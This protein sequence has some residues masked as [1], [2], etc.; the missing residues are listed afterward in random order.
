M[1]C[2]CAAAAGCPEAR[3]ISGGFG[4]DSPLARV[5]LPPTREKT[6]SV[7]LARNLRQDGPSAHMNI[8]PMLFCLLLGCLITLLTI[9][10]LLLPGLKASLLTQLPRQ[11]RGR[12]LTDLSRESISKFGG[13]SLATSFTAVSLLV[14]FFYPAAWRDGGQTGLTVLLTGLGI[15]G[16]GLWDDFRPLGTPRRLILQT[17]VAAIA[18]FRGVQIEV[19]SPPLTEFGM[20]LG[21]WSGVVTL[22][23][24]V[25]L[26][27][28]FQRINAV[29]GLAGGLGL[30]SMALLAHGAAATGTA[31][32]GLCAIGMA[33]ALIGFLV[34]NLPPTRIQLGSSGAGLLGF[35]VGNLSITAPYR[36]HQ[37][38]MVAVLFIAVIGAS[39]ATWRCAIKLLPSQSL[40]P[41]PVARPASRIGAAPSQLRDRR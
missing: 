11:T 41:K 24:L 9:P 39:F 36:E 30:F 4:I 15:F 23:W 38:A 19:L 14:C 5:H 10:L 13:A 25:L 37:S 21:G 34:Y 32:S 31:F 28:L 40:S 29:N 17:L 33:G 26:I 3:T 12:R 27:A 35:L 16:I 20:H 7:R 1:E 8:E 2:G 22:C 6:G 18:C